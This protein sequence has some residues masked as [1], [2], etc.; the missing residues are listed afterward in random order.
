MRDILMSRGARTVVEVC[1]RVVAGEN[2][3]IV[4]DTGM[5]SVARSV[6]Q[7]VYSLGANPV[8]AVM[9][10]READ[11]Q[12]PPPQVASA[13]LQSHV[14]F[15]VVSKSITHT[16]AVRDGV[17]AGSRGIMMTQFTEDM[18]IPGGIEA[19]FQNLAPL[20]RSVAQALE[21]ASHIHLMAPGGTDL[22]MSA[23]GRPGNALTCIVGPGQFSPVP[24]VEANVSPIEGSAEGI[25]TVDGSIPYA[26]IGVI[27]QPVVVHVEKGLIT[28]IAGGHEADLLRNAYAEKDDPLVYNIAELG[29]GLNPKCRFC[30]MMLEDEGVYGSVHIGTGT[31]I[32]LG[33]KVKAACHYDLIIQKPTLVADG[34]LVLQDGKVC[35]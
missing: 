9:I 5:L 10:P 29:I 32:T 28:G 23:G 31:N 3:T 4:T 30:G 27:G 16:R 12:E 11:G 6:A 35:I 33:G 15:A 21:G 14:F 18:L 26:G 7:A 1:A 13:M 22:T 24:N 17:E 2:V 8:I 34:R 20:C 19:D 25:I